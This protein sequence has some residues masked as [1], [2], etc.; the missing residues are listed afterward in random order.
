[1]LRPSVSSRSLW[2]MGALA[3]V[4]SFAA[5]PFGAGIGAVSVALILGAVVAGMFSG[6]RLESTTLIAPGFLFCAYWAVLVLHP[7]IPSV[8][9]G[10]QGWVKSC[11]IVVGVLL[12]AVWIKSTELAR[13]F[14]L[15]CL[16]V[17]C[18]ISIVIHVA[19]P[20]FETSVARTAYAAT[21]MFGGQLRMQGIFAG[22]FHVALA[23][24]FL[25]LY[26][27]L[28][29]GESRSRW[30]TYISMVVGVVA[31]QMSLVRTGYVV[32]LGGILVGLMITPIRRRL[33][34]VFRPAGIGLIL[35][36]LVVEIV[37]HP[38]QNSIVES[39]VFGSIFGISSDTRFAGRVVTWGDSW[40][41][42]LASPL[43]GYGSGSAGDTLGVF[44][45]DG[46]HVTSHNVLLKYLIEG[47]LVGFSL[48]AWFVVSL[49]RA[50]RKAGPVGPDVLAAATCLIGFGFVG[51]TVES[52]PVSV[53]LGILLGISSQPEGI[54][55][56]KRT[57]EFRRIA[58]PR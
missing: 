2:V 3:I 21:G 28:S 49:V 14:L 36:V 15:I 30:L 46:G 56:E 41:M 4:F 48:A 58:I 6:A 10:L 54:S 19:F 44:F 18:L 5:A 7:N 13:K 11:L 22:P 55:V 53:I 17:A 29:M 45:A 12:G 52:I 1:M 27:L 43:F 8:S 35:A 23:G 39:E 51:S 26:G 34:G 40:E 57:K 9:V 24:S 33:L 47:G 42:I 32:I 50:I 25:F 37:F 31:L 38:I 20:A 16:N